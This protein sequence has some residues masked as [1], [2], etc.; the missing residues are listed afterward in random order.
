MSY[1]GVKVIEARSELV[2][3]LW[4]NQKIPLEDLDKRY[5]FSQNEYVVIHCE[6]DEPTLAIARGDQIE[7]FADEGWLRAA[8]IK[9]RNREQN[10]TLHAL[11]DPKIPI[12]TLTGKA[13]TGKTLL[14]LAAAVQAMEERQY[15][16]I[17]LSRPMSNVGKYSLGTLPGDVEEKFNPYL[18]NFMC[19]LELLVGRRGR[20][21]DLIERM[22]IE[23]IPLQL[24]RGASW[25]NSYVIADE[26]QILPDDDM[27][28]LGTRLGE[29]SKLVLMGDMKQK[30]EKIARE[31]TGLYRFINHKLAKESPLVASIKLQKCERGEITRLFAEVFD[32]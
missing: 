8:G 23:F 1:T 21:G 25:S 12:V 5:R 15:E 16:R 32:R 4:E 27:V 14:A 24:I 30:D 26:V 2:A 18:E 10:M 28:A 13:G 9:A 31:K 22:G 6:G 3:K 11:M 17:I 29:N 20:V 19:N 7:L